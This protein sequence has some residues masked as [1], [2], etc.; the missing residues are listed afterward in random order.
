MKCELIHIVTYYVCIYK[1]ISDSYLLIIL[2]VFTINIVYCNI[3][4]LWVL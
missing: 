2:F 4:V 1:P 3:A